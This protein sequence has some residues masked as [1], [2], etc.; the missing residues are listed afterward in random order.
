MKD[1]LEYENARNR[2]HRA[3]YERAL[4]HAFGERDIIS[5]GHHFMISEEQVVVE[6]PSADT[7]LGD[8]FIMQ[9]LFGPRYLEVIQTLFYAPVE[10][11]DALFE[12]FLEEEEATHEHLDSAALASRAEAPR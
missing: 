7:F 1:W 2:A 10:G 3:L 6:I 8:H 12:A 9:R 4:K 5:V 11:R